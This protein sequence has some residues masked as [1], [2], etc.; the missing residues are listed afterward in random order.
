MS[1]GLRM[2]LENMEGRTFIL[3]REGHIYIDSPTAS[4]RHA[5][6]KISKGRIY[7][8]D[9]DSTNGIFLIKNNT[10]VKF[11]SGYVDPLQSVVIGDRKFIV[12]NLLEIANGFAASDDIGTKVDYSADSRSFG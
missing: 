1:S 8:R 4:K 11:E 9:L 7:L 12:K 2:E 10:L 3:G 5:E 6:I